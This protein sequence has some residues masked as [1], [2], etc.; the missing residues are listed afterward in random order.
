MF[1]GLDSTDSV[2][3]GCTTHVAAEVWRSLSEF[4]ARAGPRLV[5]L[6]PN[7]PYKTRGNGALCMELGH[8]VGRKRLAGVVRGVELYAYSRIEEPSLRDQ[9]EIVGIARDVIG[10]RRFSESNTGMIAATTGPPPD[11]YNEA[12]A[13]HVDGIPAMAEAKATTWGNGRGIIGA[14]A[15]AA[16]PMRRGTYELIAYR[17]PSRWGTRRNIPLSLGAELDAQAPSSFDNWDPRHEHLR[18]APASP[19]P[20][21]A[22][23]R[24][25]NAEELPRLL[26]LLDSEPVDSWMMF[27]TNQASG[28]HLRS[29]TLAALKPFDSAR[30]RARVSGE[31][32]TRAGGHVF[33]PV[34]DLGGDALIAAYEPTK[35]LRDSVR[36]LREGDEVVLEA[37]VHDD[38]R[39]LA[40]EA[41]EIVDAAPR[42][43]QVVECACGGGTPSKGR[44]AGR[45]CSRCG[46]T[47]HVKSVS[48]PTPFVGRVTVPTCIRRHLATPPGFSDTRLHLLPGGI[49]A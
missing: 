42:R 20:I 1:L 40:L 8:G 18:V 46:A 33:V 45:Q 21:L 38:P 31:P 29:Q 32:R 4:G 11:F 43:D 30:V 16:W 36:E 34:H 10:R 23:V 25:T 5:R 47:V 35:D 6:N 24:G 12:V 17:E 37:S 22:G 48:R 19:C 28:D 2:Q 41:M 49:A 7:V 15:A 39:Q 27:I 9:A 3:G 26:P 13:K 14:M 44:R